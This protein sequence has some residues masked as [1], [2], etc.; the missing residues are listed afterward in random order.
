MFAQRLKELRLQANL[1]QK[2]IADQ[3]NITQPT[4][5]GWE[6]GK[7]NPSGKTLEKLSL[8]F[9]VSI[10]YLLGKDKT[11]DS[12]STVNLIPRTGN[13]RMTNPQKK[14]IQEET[15]EI[16]KQILTTQEQILEEL[17]KN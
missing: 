12:I 5:Q 14:T 4:Y 8:L 7:R 13:P 1:T 3:L 17:K 10:D 16:L 9:N 6:S 2:D 11:T 15:L